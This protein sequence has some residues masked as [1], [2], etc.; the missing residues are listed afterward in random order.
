ML[1]Q[2]TELSVVL[3]SFEI[4]KSDLTPADVVMRI[5]GEESMYGLYSKNS[6]LPL[7]LFD[8]DAF[9]ER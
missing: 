1:L 8:D 5:L 9:D 4:N 7:E 3:D 6:Y 2:E